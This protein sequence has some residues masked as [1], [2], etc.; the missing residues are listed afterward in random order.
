MGADLFFPFVWILADVQYNV[1]T[2]SA[3][4]EA[5]ARKRPWQSMC[6]VTSGMM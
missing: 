6:N 5:D 1:V 4:G 3:R 2:T